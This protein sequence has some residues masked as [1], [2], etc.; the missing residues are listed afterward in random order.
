MVSHD[1]R[2]PLQSIEA[3]TSWIEEDYKTILDAP[4]KE[5]L[6]LIRSN[7]LIIDT[8]VKGTLEYATIGK[9]EN[10]F[11]KIA[12][13]SLV[14]DILKKITEKSNVKVLMPIK[15][16]IITGDKYRIEKLFF[17]IIDNAIKYTDKKAKTIEIGFSE[18]DDYWSFYIKDFGIGIKEKYFDKVFIAFQKLD[19]S[20]N[21]VGLGLAVVKKIIG[22]YNGQIWIESTPNIGSTF[23]FNLKK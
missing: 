2:S 1:L 19:S 3:L 6:R 10:K 21:S 13:E 8:I 7:V 14:K 12:V 23:Y 5:I 11:S 20:N 16:P 15:L 22:I 17:H 9:I 4:G 18:D